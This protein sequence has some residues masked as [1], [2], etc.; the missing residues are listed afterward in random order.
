MRRRRSTGRRSSSWSI[1]APPTRAGARRRSRRSGLRAG[2]LRFSGRA[3]TANGRSRWRRSPCAS[4]ASAS[5]AGAA[6][7][8]MV[9]EAPMPF[10][11]LGMSFLAS[12]EGWEARGTGSCSIG[13][14]PER[15]LQDHHGRVVVDRLALAGP[16]QPA[17]GDR[18]LD[19]EGRQPLVLQQ[20]RQ[21]ERA[22]PA[23]R[24]RRAPPWPSAPRC[25]PC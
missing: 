6:S 20:H 3:S 24:P 23:R 21:P 19:R 15:I 10:S 12:L 4:S 14:V 18:V 22:R 8:A 2:Q 11:L 13:E 17:L 5:S 16:R 25:R 9:N 1:A 7:P